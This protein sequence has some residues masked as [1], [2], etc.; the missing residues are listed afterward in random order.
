MQDPLAGPSA[1]RDI[2]RPQFNQV[3]L[4]AED[5]VKTTIG[6]KLDTGI[7]YFLRSLETNKHLTN[8]MNIQ[9]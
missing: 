1:L 3:N 9:R 2:I 6:L 5:F 7:V 4:S 8:I